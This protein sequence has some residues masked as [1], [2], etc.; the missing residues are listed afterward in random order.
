[1]KIGQVVQNSFGII[2]DGDM[3]SSFILDSEDH[4]G[5]DASGY[6]KGSVMISLPSVGGATSIRMT[7]QFSDDPDSGIWHD[8]I[9]DA[10]NPV[11]YE[12][13]NLSND[14]FVWNFGVPTRMIRLKFDIIGS[15]VSGTDLIK[16]LLTVSS[17]ESNSISE[18]M[19][20]SSGGGGGLTPH[21][22]T[23]E[24]GGSDK[25]NVG[26]LSG[27]LAEPQHPIRSAQIVIVA[28]SGGDFTSVGSALAS[29]TDATNTK[30]YTIIVESGVFAEA[31]LTC[32]S[33]VNITGRNK[34]SILTATDNTLPLLTTDS[35][36]T[37]ENLTIAGPF[38][39]IGVNTSVKTRVNVR[40]CNFVGCTVAIYYNSSDGTVQDCFSTSGVTNFLICENNSLVSASGMLSYSQVSYRSDNSSLWI[41]NSGIGSGL[42]GISAVNNGTVYPSNITSNNCS[43]VVH[44]GSA[45]A[46]NITGNGIV[47]RGNSNFDILQENNLSNISLT[48]CSMDGQKIQAVDFKRINVQ[49]SSRTEEQE[50]YVSTVSGSFGIPEH[51]EEL[52][53]GEGGGTSRGIRV[54]EYLASTSS[55]TNVTAAAKSAIGSTF[56]I[57]GTNVNDALYLSWDLE[58]QDLSDKKKFFGIK[59]NIIQAAVLGAGEIVIEAWDGS[60][61]SWVNT[62]SAQETGKKLPFTNNEIFQRTGLESVRL[63]NR[64]DAQWV[65]NDPVSIGNNQYWVRFRIATAINTNPIFEHLNLFPSHTHIGHDGWINFHGKARPSK[66]IPWDLGLLQPAN[67]SPANRDTY[68]SDRLGVGRIENE[69]ANGAVDRLGMNTYLP[70]DIDTSCPIYLRWSLA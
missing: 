23:H 49:F 10:G 20:P 42:Y 22:A 37:I 28:K 65:K 21:H 5:Y 50:V 61:W 32:K 11:Y 33:F 54:Y 57:P 67:S 8:L 55:F 39:S 59:F 26:G 29:I 16:V 45:G 41:H 24:S 31:P 66:V 13:N 47:S 4:L 40:E 38:S 7:I 3:Q 53:A 68:V 44:T 60:S 58:D 18:Q 52:Q 12:N 35:N 64:L 34:N 70:F 51:G 15:L 46:N 2:Y 9:N 48:G 14:S 17:Y 19:T 6:N 43:I 63:D 36:M 62:M 1:M 69:F 30:P 56:S 27:V 25:V